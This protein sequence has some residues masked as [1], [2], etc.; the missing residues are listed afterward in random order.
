MGNGAG[1]MA[2]PPEK[3]KGKNPAGSVSLGGVTLNKTEEEKRDDAETRGCISIETDEIPDSFEVVNEEISSDAAVVAGRELEPP[4]KDKVKAALELA[5]QN[6]LNRGSRKKIPATPKED[7]G[8]GSTNPAPGTHAGSSTAVQGTPVSNAEASEVD[9]LSAA[10]P[11]LRTPR[12][13]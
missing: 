7:K 12:S 2:N 3:D 10:P 6:R 9:P 5:L 11:T 13:E 8:K 4:N 1:R